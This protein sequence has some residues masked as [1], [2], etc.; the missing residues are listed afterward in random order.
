MSNKRFN[1]GNQPRNPWQRDTDDLRQFR[2]T[3][4][5]FTKKTPFNSADD[6]LPYEIHLWVK[7]GLA[8]CDGD[9]KDAWV[10]NPK[11]PVV[12]AYENN[13]LISLQDSVNG[14]LQ[15]GDII[16]MSF[17]IGFVFGRKDWKLEIRPMD[18]IRVGR[19]QDV[20]HIRGSIIAPQDVQ[21]QP[22]PVGWVTLTTEGL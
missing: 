17:T 11:R 12:L 9:E 13:E 19:P 16:W 1:L 20:V 7:K 21:R 14:N 15:E 8:E 6:P 22:L 18:L 4:P 10:P 3:S 2:M 5:I